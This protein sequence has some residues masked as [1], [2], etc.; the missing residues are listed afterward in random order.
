MPR[1][2]LPLISFV[3]LMTGCAAEPDAPAVAGRASLAA[4]RIVEV[5][6]NRPVSQAALLDRLVAA[7]YVLLGEKHDN[8]EHH[9]LQ[10]EITRALATGRSEP[11]AVAFE[12]MGTDQQI[13]V[14]EH[15]QAHPG[16]A[17]DLGAA[18]DWQA[19]GW[20]DWSM[21]APIAQAAL[22]GGG[23]IVA[24]NL[25]A[26]RVREVYASGTSALRATLVRRTGLGDQLPELLALDLRSD[27]EQ[28]H[29][30]H[31]VPE[32][33]DGMFRVQR[34]RDAIMADR[35]VAA[36]G[37]GGGILV[38]GAEHVRNDRG[39]PWYIARLDPQADVVSIAFLEQDEVAPSA[40]AQAASPQDLPFDYVWFTS[41]VEG[42][43]P[44]ARF[45]EQ[46]EQRRQAETPAE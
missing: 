25:P 33:V 40:G 28:A 23:A 31:A 42:G 39:V 15:L 13:A 10:A 38:A 30:G 35:L 18:L 34:A 45:Q 14:V 2:L 27:L 8:P 22:D 7:D 29:C 3:M 4:E 36:S 41:A 26:G 16:D 46:L 12:M 32:M 19:S 11:R 5:A 21:Y 43:D 17:S 44:C 24:A 20:P 1:R 6:T 37:R 9:R